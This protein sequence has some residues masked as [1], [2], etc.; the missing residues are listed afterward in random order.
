MSVTIMK[1]KKRKRRLGVYFDKRAASRI[2]GSFCGKS[3]RG[4][5]E[6]D[7]FTI[8]QAGKEALVQCWY[9][10]CLKVETRRVG[11]VGRPEEIRCSR[12][13]GKVEVLETRD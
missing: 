4:R 2:A 6:A 12:C 11:I 7:R 10:R 8:K 9:S 3:V 13:G 1:K 5:E